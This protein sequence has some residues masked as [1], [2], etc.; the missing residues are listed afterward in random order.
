MTELKR[1]SKF[2]SVILRHRAADFGVELDEHGFTDYAA[3]RAFVQSRSHDQYTDADWETILTGGVDGRKRFEVANGRI[4]ALY[5]HS[6]VTPI[7]YDP[8]APPDIL[9]HGTTRQ[10]AK[11]IRREGLRSMKRQ[12][13]HL[14]ADTERAVKVAGRRTEDAVLLVVRAAEAHRSGIEFYHPE[15]EHF[16]AKAI[17]SSFIEFPED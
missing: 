4:R 12:Y 14:S 17:P 11:A 7:L 5:G 15:P 8:V 16:L 10:A 2:V 13:V 6:R 3:L 9:Y 1:L